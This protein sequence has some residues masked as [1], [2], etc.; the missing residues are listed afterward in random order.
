M[1]AGF[2]GTPEFAVRALEA[3]HHHRFEIPV[4]LTQ[5]DRRAGRGMA[6]SAS[7]VKRFAESRGIPVLQP[8]T[9]RDADALAA[10][11][12]IQLDVLVVAAY[13]LI[14]PQAVLDWPR[15]GCINIHASLLPR[16]RGA[17]PMTRAIEAGDSVTGI[18]IMQMDAGLDT[19]PVIAR[20]EVP[21]GSRETAATLE[22]KLSE[23]GARLI[24]GVLRAL[25]EGASLPRAP[26][27]DIG[28]TYAAKISRGDRLVRWSARAEE[29]DR[30]VRAL[31]PAPGAVATWKGGPVRIAEAQP[32]PPGAEAPAGAE[33]AA[34]CEVLAVGSEGIDVQCGSATRLRLTALQPSG[35][36][37]MPAHA[38]A[39][40]RGVR[41]GDRF[42]V[43]AV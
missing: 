36:R 21:I 42:E 3:I 22:A 39:V 35:G 13:G 38:F 26:Q 12:R 19:G 9:L 15:H 40:G 14:L 4:V 30:K 33:A 37:V 29:I 25:D 31:T 17:A 8:T 24:I 7:A 20:E 2:A 10:L 16:W 32:L 6:L 1:R 41:R 27:P 28:V 18:T 11:R 23:V 43:A 34:S 5:P